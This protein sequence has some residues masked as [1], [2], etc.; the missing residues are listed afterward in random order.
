MW[1][2]V[3]RT[4]QLYRDREIIGVGYS[5]KAEAKNDPAKQSAHNEGPIPCGQYSIGD[6]HDSH[7]H[8]PFVLPLAP[9]MDNQMFGRSAFLCHGDSLKDPGTASD[10]CIIMTRKVRETIAASGDRELRVVA[11]PIQADSHMPEPY[12][13]NKAV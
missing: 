10:G 8:G 2:Y 11:D 4:G 3:Q 6:P 5:G 9:A 13:S 1:F 7:D 12:S